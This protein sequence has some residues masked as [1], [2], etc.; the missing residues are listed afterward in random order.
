MSEALIVNAV[1]TPVGKRNGVLSK[2]RPDDLLALALREL[3]DRVGLDPALVED[4]IAG[5]VT[6]NRGAIDERGA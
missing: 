3:V 2:V 4:V 6:K 5:C 1:R